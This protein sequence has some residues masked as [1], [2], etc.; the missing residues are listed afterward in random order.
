M[1]YALAVSHS[2]VLGNVLIQQLWLRPLALLQ[3]KRLSQHHGVLAVKVFAA[4][5]CLA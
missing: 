3:Q 4:L 5:S 1:L 2:F